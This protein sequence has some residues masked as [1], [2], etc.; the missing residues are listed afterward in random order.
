V[1]VAFAAGGVKTFYDDNIGFWK[2]CAEVDRR[3]AG[4]RTC[5]LP[6]GWDNMSLPV[7]YETLMARRPTP[8]VTVQILIDAVR[9]R[10]VAA[11]DE[12]A[13]VERLLRCDAAAREEL[14]A[15]IEEKHGDNHG[16]VR[17]RW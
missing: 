6:D 4:K 17:L 1:N 11:L 13:N 9:L 5:P 14:N 15:S 16:S 2:Y 12:P 8:W 10:G 3:L 7:L